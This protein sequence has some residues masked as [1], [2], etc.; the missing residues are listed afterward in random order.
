MGA[1]SGDAYEKDRSCRWAA[2]AG[3][4][5]GGPLKRGWVFGFLDAR[6]GTFRVD[7]AVLSK[8]C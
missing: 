5:S 4:A 7:Q 1:G 2:Y 3:W 6:E 8:S